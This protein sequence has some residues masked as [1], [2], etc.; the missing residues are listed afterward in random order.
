MAP[1]LLRLIPIRKLPSFLKLSIIGAFFTFVMVQNGRFA[2]PRDV[3]IDRHIRFEKYQK[4]GQYTIV[5]VL[6]VYLC[7]CSVYTVKALYYG[8][9]YYG[10]P[11]IMDNNKKPRYVTFFN[12]VIKTPLLWTLL[13]DCRLLR[14]LFFGPD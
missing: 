6:F 10:Q 9:L 7:T 8:P 14:T 4:S 2:V 1:R 3:M 11:P 13:M 5:V 12:S